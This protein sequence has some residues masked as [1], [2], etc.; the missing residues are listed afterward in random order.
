MEK[1][2]P[3]AATTAHP[4]STISLV[5]HRSLGTGKGS[6]R[7]TNDVAQV[8]ENGHARND[9]KKYINMVDRDLQIENPKSPT[10]TIH[11]ILTTTSKLK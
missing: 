1:E 2:K 9:D 6:S 11:E 5:V 4:I 3:R 8:A 10:I 7:Y